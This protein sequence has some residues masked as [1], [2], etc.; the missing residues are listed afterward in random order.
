[1]AEAE[2]KAAER[3]HL[4]HQGQL[5]RLQ[6]LQGVKPGP[7][8]TLKMKAI[9]LLA[10]QA[11]ERR[12]AAKEALIQVEDA[13]EEAIAT[14]PDPTGGGMEV[15]GTSPAGPGA[16]NFICVDVNG[17]DLV[18]AQGNLNPLYIPPPFPGDGECRT[19]QAVAMQR[20]CQE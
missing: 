9:Q 4:R 13:L 11:Q 17:N 15:Q 6:G 7:K 16:V 20:R 1:M 10:S 8:R 12:Q 18:D 5:R 14:L 2:E 19:R 3:A